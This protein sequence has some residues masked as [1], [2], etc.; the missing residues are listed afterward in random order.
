[1]LTRG[2]L[3]LTPH[4]RLRPGRVGGRSAREF[5]RQSISKRACRLTS[6]KSKRR[7]SSV[8]TNYQYP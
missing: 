6:V 1:L 2:L 7:T 5:L 8:V 3:T 4:S